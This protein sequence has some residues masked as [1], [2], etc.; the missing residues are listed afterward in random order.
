VTEDA[1]ILLVCESIHDVLAAEKVLKQ[2][3]LWCDLVPTPREISS[4]CGMS[5]TCRR[6]D[7]PALRA[8]VTAGGEV[9]RCRLHGGGED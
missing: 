3:G 8:L 1:T 2:R 7:L 5:L 6:A 4:D 9:S